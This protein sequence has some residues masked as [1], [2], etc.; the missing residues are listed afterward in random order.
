M[1]D[2]L[3]AQLYAVKIISKYEEY[4][5]LNALKKSVSRNNTFA[6]L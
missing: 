3:L 4:A 1:Y 6:E 2:Y 5:Q